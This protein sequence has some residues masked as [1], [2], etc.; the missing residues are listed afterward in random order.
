MNSMSRKEPWSQASRYQTRNAFRKRDI[1]SGVHHGFGTLSEVRFSS[2]S[3]LCFALKAGIF[4]LSFVVEFCFTL[5]EAAFAAWLVVLSDFFFECVGGFRTDLLF[6][7]S[8]E[9]LPGEK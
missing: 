4:E 7:T 6:G 9:M 8:S 1:S 3:F 5:G 2:F